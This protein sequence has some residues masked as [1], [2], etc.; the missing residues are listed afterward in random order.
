M[1][2]LRYNGHS[3]TLNEILPFMKWMF[4]LFW[5]SDPFFVRQV[6]TQE[7][8]YP[9]AIYLEIFGPKSKST[10]VPKAAG[11][12]LVGF[13]KF[14]LQNFYACLP[15]TLNILLVAY[16]NH[17]IGGCFQKCGPKCCRNLCAV[18]C[19]ILEV[20]VSTGSL[21]KFRI[22]Y[23]WLIPY[24]YGF[25]AAF[26]EVLYLSHEKSKCFSHRGPS[27]VGKW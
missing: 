5:T 11:R 4:R 25:V 23:F 24:H 6:V 2:K 20:P 17:W 22:N 26:S 16:L 3:E 27:W 7:C 15:G 9:K 14:W 18:C 1:C 21:R 8:R 19:P 10:N 13:V 12:C